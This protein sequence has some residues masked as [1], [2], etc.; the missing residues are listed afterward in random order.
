MADGP[1]DD[2]DPDRDGEE[3]VLDQFSIG[4]TVGEP[5]DAS[6]G[7]H[8]TDADRDD[9]RILTPSERAARA[10]DDGTTAAADAGRDDVVRASDF[11]GDGPVFEEVVRFRQ[12]WL[13][14]SVIGVSLFS[15]VTWL[16]NPTG[17][18]L[19]AILLGVPVVGTVG[20]YVA[21][22]ETAVH[23]DGLHL[24]LFPLHRTERVVRFG[25]VTGIERSQV[26]VFGDFGGIGIRRVGGTWA[27]VVESGDAVTLE[28]AEQTDVL[29]TTRRAEDLERALQVGLS[30]ARGV[31]GGLDDRW[32]AVA[33]LD[34]SRVID[35]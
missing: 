32:R 29:V 5:A 11:D 17:T 9:D 26:G 18:L 3:S 2:S 35:S 27:Y 8:E 33:N 24:R 25:D 34:D 14:V 6:N 7:H 21:R 28:R 13:W 19:T 4:D 15:V 20:T 22:L 30:R 23:A 1:D 12:R 10:A 16:A 31:E